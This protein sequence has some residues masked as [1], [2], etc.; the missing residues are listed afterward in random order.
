MII[1]MMAQ[2]GG[3]AAAETERTMKTNSK[4]N[5]TDI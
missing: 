2:H 5:L 4:D 1:M 3:N